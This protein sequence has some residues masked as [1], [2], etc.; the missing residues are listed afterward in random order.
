VGVTTLNARLRELLNPKQ[1]SL[2]EMRIGG[3]VLREEDRIMIVR[4]DYKLEVFNGDVG[5]VVTID[6]KKKEIEIKIHGPP[7]MHFWI[8]FEKAPS[9]LRLAYA[10]TVH[11][12]QGQEYDVILM[13]VVNSFGHQLQRNL[14]YTA[15]TRAK[16]RVILVGTKAALIRAVM[17]ERESARN[18]LL[19]Q[20]LLE[21]SASV[22]EA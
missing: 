19:M 12:S 16:K 8:P 2:H 1:A 5:K 6:K 3:D 7:V 18:T 13:P 17:N 22:V 21:G 10:V 20:R 15:I 11:K 4:N 9:L 14:L